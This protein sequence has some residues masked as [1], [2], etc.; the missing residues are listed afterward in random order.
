MQRSIWVYL[1]VQVF[2]ARLGASGGSAANEPEPPVAAIIETTLR[3]ASG[4]IRQFAFDGDG[5][6]CFVSDQTPCSTDHFTL[7]LDRTVAVKSIVVTTGRPDGNDRL[8]AGSLEASEDGTTFSE[9]MKLVDGVARGELRGRKIRAVRIRPRAELKRPLAI[10]ELAIESEPAVAV[11]KYPIEFIVDVTDA[12]EMREW[13]EKVAA[14]CE[15][16]YP[17]INEELKAE[18]FKPP[19]LVT[20]TLKKDFRGVAAASGTRITGSVKFFSDHPD[21]V[22]AMVHETVH[23]VQRYRSRTNPGWLVEGVADYVRFFKYEPGKLGRIN[24]ERA[25]YNGS[26]RVTAAFLAYLNGTYDQEIVRK[27]NRVMR[28]GQYREEVFKELTG[29]TVQELGEEWKATLRRRAR[30]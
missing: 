20:M 28:E 3:T 19:H 7:V 27:L 15:R 6:T 2:C 25:R 30:V 4:Q 23:V 5:D 16:A 13:A 22:G 18:G 21:D 26:Y 9:I 14:V 12:P 11:F 24:P 1:G 29:K 17:M 8:E 10:R